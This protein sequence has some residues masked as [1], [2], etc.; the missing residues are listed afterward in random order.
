MGSIALAIVL[1]AGI[2][3]S[4]Q[5]TTLDAEVA[6]LTARAQAMSHEFHSASAW[7]RLFDEIDQL[8]MAAENAADWDAAID[9]Q[10]LKAMVLSDVLNEQPRALSVVQQ[11][12]K[13]YSGRE[14]ERM[15]KLYVREAEIYGK[16]GDDAAIGRLIDQFKVSP[17]YDP[18]PYEYSGGRGRDVPLALTRP[19]GRGD[20]SISVT[21]MEVARQQA[22]AAAGRA[23]PA[24]TLTDMQ[25]KTLRLTDYR[26]KVLLVDFW[27]QRWTPWVRD[28]PSQV[29]AYRSYHKQGLEIIGINLDRNPADL[30]SF[31]RR[32]GM[33][34]PQVT[35]DTDLARKLGVFGEAA[36]FLVDRNGYV[37]ARDLHGADLAEAVR[38]ALA[39]E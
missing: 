2:S 21:A 30:A 9:G 33:A 17:Y 39:R 10:L 15:H 38:Q 20:D 18:E 22:R 6:A 8:I 32:N 34:W 29:A 31:I 36:N 23:F 37:I 19:D 28:L 5:G 16:R 13:R 25:G 7:N 12:R 35:G 11:A 26:G 1:G 24:F 14:V 4:A 3:F 27:L